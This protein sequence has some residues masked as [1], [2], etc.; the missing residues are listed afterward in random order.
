MQ[1]FS[2]FWL[3][4]HLGSVEISFWVYHYSWGSSHFDVRFWD[5]HDIWTGDPIVRANLGTPRLQSFDRLESTQASSTFGFRW[6]V[7][8]W[9]YA[10]VFLLQISRVKTKIFVFS[11]KN[12]R[13]PHFCFT[14]PT[15]WVWR[16]LR[17]ENCRKLCPRLESSVRLVQWKSVVSCSKSHWY[18]WY[19]WFSLIGCFVILA[20]FWP[21]LRW[22]NAIKYQIPPAESRPAVNFPWNQTI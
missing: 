3:K 22:W 15:T 5:R 1:N 13:W 20:G 10:V 17:E 19:P 11:K 2:F 12:S 4:R 9:V 16:R 21:W 6:S 7:I 8:Y 18:Y 14:I